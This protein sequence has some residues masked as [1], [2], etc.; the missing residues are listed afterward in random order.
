MDVVQR[1]G[2]HVLFDF[3]VFPG[4]GSDQLSE[5][6]VRGVCD[7]RSMIYRRIPIGCAGSGDVEKHL[8]SDEGCHALMQLVQEGSRRRTAFLADWWSRWP[9]EA[10]LRRNG[11]APLRLEVFSAR[12]SLLLFLRKGEAL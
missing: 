10:E 2:V 11:H 6:A 1:E 8:K 5:E 3:R 7:Q 9:I 12:P 4:I